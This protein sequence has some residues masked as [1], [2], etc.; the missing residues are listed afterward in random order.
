MGDFV[1]QG[2]GIGFSVVVGMLV[3]LW[4][5]PCLAQLG[6]GLAA[7]AEDTSQVE[8][9]SKEMDLLKKEMSEQQAITSSLQREIQSVKNNI[10]A[11]PELADQL[12]QEIKRL[13]Q[14]SDKTEPPKAQNGL[15]TAISLLEAQAKALQESLSYVLGQIGEQQALP[16]AAREEVK[17]AQKQS[18]DLEQKIR[19]QQNSVKN[20]SVKALQLS[21]LKQ[22]LTNA[23]LRKDLAQN[24]LEG[25]QKLLDLYTVNRDLLF[26]R[27]EMLKSA[28]EMLRQERDEKRLQTAGE[29]QD[30]SVVLQGEYQQLPAV[31]SAELKENQRLRDLLVTRTADLNNTADEL[32]AGK[33]ELQDIRYRFEV[34]KQQLELTEYYQFVDDYLLRQRQLLQAKIREQESSTTLH[35]DISR[36]RL[37]QFK[38]D[39]K[40]HAVRT[41]TARRQFIASQLQGADLQSDQLQQD[42][43]R[44]CESRATLLTKLVQVNADY[45][46]NLTNLELLHGDQL[47]ERRQ[48][49]EL[50]N[51]KLFWRR[52]ATPLDWQWLSLLPGSIQWFV[53]DQPWSE[54]F[55]IWYQWLV[56]PVFPLVLLGIVAA[57][58]VGGRRKV[59][60]R[61]EYG[62]HKIGNVT[63]DRFRYSLE[64]LLGTVL[65][66]LPL[67]FVLLV[68]AFPVLR[69]NEAT[70]FGLGIG[71]ALVVM[72]RWLFL[73]EFIRLLARP[74][75][76]AEG[77]FRWRPSALTA[78]KRW[79][80]LL[81][82]QLPCAFV[83][84][85]VWREGDEFHSGILGRAAFLLVAMLFVVY[86]IRMFSPKSGV[87]QQDD[88]KNQHWYQRWNRALFWVCVLIPGALVLLS[89]QGYSFSAM[90][91]MVLMY[92]TL[93]YGFFIFILEQ[94]LMR[95]FAVLERKLAYARAIE[96][97]DAQRK[98]KEQQ[99]EAGASGEAVP[100]IE[101][102]SLDVATISEQ[103]R[104][105][106]RVLA[107]SV[108]A[109]VCYLS[110][111]DFF[112]AIQIFQEIELWTYSVTTDAGVESH[113]VTLE[114]L[115]AVSLALTLSYVGVKNLPGLIEV[116]I[117]QRLK[118]DSGIRFAIT[119]TAR[120]L[121]I[122]AGV[123]IVSGMIGLEWSKLGWL[124]A[125][126]GVGLGFGLQ[127][128]FANFISG[129]IILFERPI[130]I[131]DTV[132]INDLSGT[133]SQ[134]RMRATTITDW[135]Q[136]E[137]IIPNKTFVTNQFINWTLSDSTTRVVIKVGVAYG[138]DT[139][140][141]SRTLM[142]IAQANQIVLKEPA[143]S[144]FFLGFGA[145][146]LD[147]ELRAFV[148]S[149][150]K[151]LILIHE[152]HTAIDKRFK[153]LGIEIAFP[154][155]DLHVKHLPPGQPPSQP[156]AES[157]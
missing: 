79:L 67:P 23:N 103:N 7:P 48:F 10:Q 111:Q 66:A 151:R 83:F 107:F 37:E 57:V 131:G 120:Y 142:E 53:M 100:D 113:T 80:P 135:D 122:I 54:P 70:L 5:L 87:T 20:E 39:E 102:P 11:A 138:S 43:Y 4:T 3:W 124:V 63:K 46:V 41:D 13:E 36:A 68:L 143:P 93:M 99:E 51:K 126:L 98:V 141:V 150:S 21:V 32:V 52:S 91:I 49:Y 73:F 127:E 38:L 105:L 117:L 140:L 6:V 69:S 30:V 85:V 128:I 155:L 27:M 104:A 144:A 22:Q 75:G 35:E 72:A 86:C 58:Y 77:H 61:M 106:L 115:F 149:F 109:V 82:L 137:L 42:L 139:D 116:L 26:M 84:I 129:L 65:L 18:Q 101:L 89:V 12:R 130:R 34:A 114:T 88:G 148:A 157:A 64:S 133:V 119:T 19:E 81:Y 25:Y 108:F 45:V 76:L 9:A 134:I 146:S 31:L 16:S 47:A 95:W 2:K 153:E 14:R 112:Q 40:L 71:A 24:R 50:L 1:R 55:V 62:T 28:L 96:K 59:I 17:T 97:R 147:F 121:V 78:L 94:V 56:Q 44:I 15:D 125:A 92:Q 154:Q 8:A 60:Q 90:E 156:G 118:V 110:W 74:N 123:M 29:Q 136:K 33:Q 132:T 152:L 145:S